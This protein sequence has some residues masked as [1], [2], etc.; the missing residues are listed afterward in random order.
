MICLLFPLNI[1]TWERSSGRNRPFL[2][3]LIMLMIVLLTSFQEHHYLP[4]GCTTCAVSSGKVWK[5]ISLIPSPP[6]SFYP[7]L[8]QLVQASSLWLKKMAL[9][10]NALISEV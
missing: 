7:H 10:I 6:E 8:L 2:Y 4:A 1:M 3:L 5:N 9:W